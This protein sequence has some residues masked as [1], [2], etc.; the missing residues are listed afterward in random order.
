[1]Q[2]GLKYSQIFYVLQMNRT[3]FCSL[4]KISLTVYDG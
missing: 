1:M 4:K 3:H 2:F